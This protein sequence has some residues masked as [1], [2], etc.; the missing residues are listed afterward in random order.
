MWFLNSGLDKKN[1][2]QV[3]IFFLILKTSPI[4]VTALLIILGMIL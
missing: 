1:E 3:I 4:W 2:R